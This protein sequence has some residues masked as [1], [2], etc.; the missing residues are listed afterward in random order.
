MEQTAAM[1]AEME[2]ERARRLK[3]LPSDRRPSHCRELVDLREELSDEGGLNNAVG[4]KKEYDI[5]LYWLNN[6]ISLA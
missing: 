6:K 4:I 1:R 3:G 5:L 2:V